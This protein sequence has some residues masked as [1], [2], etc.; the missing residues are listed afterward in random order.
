MRKIYLLFVGLLLALG[1]NAQTI[2]VQDFETTDGYL[3]HH[4]D[5]TDGSGDYIGRMTND[6]ISPDFSGFHG[7]YFFAAQDIDAAGAN[8]YDTTWIG[9][10]DV[11]SYDGTYIFKVLA[12]QAYAS[13]NNWDDNDFV[14]ID[15]SFDGTNY[16]PLIWLENDGSQYNGPTLLDSDFDGTGDTP[17][18]LSTAMKDLTAPI[19][20][21]GQSTLYI[22]IDM[23]LDAGGEDIALDYLRLEQPATTPSLQSVEYYPDRLVLTYDMPLD[24]FKVDYY[25]VLSNGNV[26]TF[27]SIDHNSDSTQVYLSNPSMA[28]AND[29][30]IDTLVDSLSGDTLTFYGGIIPLNYLNTAST[31]VIP[32]GQRVVI[33]GVVTANSNYKSIFI[34]DAPGASHGIMVYDNSRY[35][36]GQVSV[37]D[38]VVFIGTRT[39][40]Y[41][42]TEFIPDSL[43]FK[44]TPTSLSIDPVVIDPNVIDIH[45]TADNSVSEPYEGVLVTVENVQCVSGPTSY[46]EYHL[47]SGTDTIIVD[48]GLDYQYGD[49]LTLTPG[50]NYTITGVVNYSYGHYRLNPRGVDDVVDL[51]PS[52]ISATYYP[53]N[54]LSV[55]YSGKVL[56]IDANNYVVHSSDGMT[57]TFSSC[58]ANSDSTVL[59]LSGISGS[60]TTDAVL[61]TLFDLYGGDTLL[62]YLGVIPISNLNAASSD[63]IENGYSVAVSGVVT[64]DNDYKSIFIADGQGEYHGLLVYDPSQR[65]ASMVAPG[66]SV[67]FVGKRSDS[68]NM[69]KLIPDS[70]FFSGTPSVLSIE[71]VTVDASVLDIHQ[72]ANSAVTEPYEGVLVTVENVQCVSGPTGY[73]EYYLVSGTDTIIV[74]DGLDYQYGDG[75]TLTQGHTYTIT[76]LVN[77]SYGHYRLNPR[78]VAD[79]QEVT[80]NVENTKSVM[81]YPNPVEN[82]L[83][84]VGVQQVRIY[85][86]SGR[87]IKQ[88]LINNSGQINLTGLQ[89]G[90]YVVKYVTTDGKLGVQKI[91]KR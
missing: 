43:F 15:Y 71:P 62:F 72:G 36:P 35:Y 51:T 59:T 68:Y 83:N 82:V 76:G 16:Q 19:D 81:I 33:S 39:V 28:F 85:D 37:G 21:T 58:N 9:P 32:N 42:M 89:S 4:P 79:V 44:G 5:S 84:L 55:L 56:N 40:S 69:T 61:D 87:L 47:V 75:L 50:H 22:R 80:A 54:T 65:Y 67:V 52:S 86:N 26:I 25:K 64:G 73:Y 10:I 14:H 20:L 12:G 30:V 48:D 3:R 46:Y 18:N 17:V 57:L 11:S 34:A 77:Y 8:S 66:D 91:L 88:A 74:D 29:A 70:L 23:H 53:D 13:S 31:Q 6:S 41:N 45:Q 78:G 27:G 2:T 90:V 24:S 63:V 1:L 49:G 38:S 7:T 60:F